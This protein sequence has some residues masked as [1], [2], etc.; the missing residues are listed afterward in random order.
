MT[1]AFHKHR[2]NDA[3][4]DDDDADAAAAVV[5]PNTPFR[6]TPPATQYQP[7][8]LHYSRVIP[9]LLKRNKT[10]LQSPQQLNVYSPLDCHYQT[11][12][13]YWAAAADAA[14]PNSPIVAI[15][16]AV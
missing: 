9:H 15:S 7:R 2:S 6:L 3:A 16:N 14:I 4:A 1:K 10:Q 12:R 11:R 8:H 13:C 5:P